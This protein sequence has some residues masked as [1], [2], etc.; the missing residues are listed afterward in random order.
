MELYDFQKEW[1]ENYMDNKFILHNAA[2]QSG[3][4]TIYSIIYLWEMTFGYYKNILIVANNGDS[5]KEVVERVKLLYENLPFFLKCGIIKYTN[6]EIIFE[7]RTSIS[8]QTRSKYPIVGKQYH[9]IHILEY[10]FIPSNYAE[11]LFKSIVPVISALRDTK[12]IISSTLNGKN[13]FYK[14]C[15]DAKRK[16]KDPFKNNFKLIET[17]W[18][19]VPGRD[20]EWREETIKILGSEDAF[21]Q[22]YDLQI[23]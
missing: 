12:F 23:I 5:A 3:I 6:S 22:E 7:N 19:E 16:D 1:L 15:F 9:I 20:M 18:W 13:H 4:S 2:R 14:L 11:T 10:A 21:N 8:Y 17:Y